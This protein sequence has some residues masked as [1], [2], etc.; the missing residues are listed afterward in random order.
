M[1]LKKCESF[2]K[3]I[4]EEIK[5]FF[6]EIEDDIRGKTKKCDICHEEI[7]DDLREQFEETECKNRVKCIH[8]NKYLVKVKVEN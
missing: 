1:N 8:C 2:L 6:D 7:P 5:D 3:K 4:G